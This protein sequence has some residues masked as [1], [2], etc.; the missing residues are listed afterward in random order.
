MHIVISDKM[1]NNLQDLAEYIPTCFDMQELVSLSNEL[2]EH[3]ISKN[4]M[5]SDASMLFFLIKRQM[6]TLNNSASLSNSTTKGNERVKSLTMNP[7]GRPTYIHS[8]E[9]IVNIGLLALNIIITAIMYGFL[10]IHLFI[11]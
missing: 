3:I 5:A 2:L 11:K 7:V 10:F 4:I 9:G 6:N 1:I 8:S